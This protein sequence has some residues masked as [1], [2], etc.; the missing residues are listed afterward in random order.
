MEY[1]AVHFHRHL[2]IPGNK[3]IIWE[4][5]YAQGTVGT[6]R[7]TNQALDGE[8]KLGT[9]YI[10]ERSVLHEC[11]SI[12]GLQYFGAEP[13]FNYFAAETGFR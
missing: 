5:M 11:N 12:S 10:G 1:I 7:A 2:E 6:N 8:Q 3:P 13:V 9:N 4:P